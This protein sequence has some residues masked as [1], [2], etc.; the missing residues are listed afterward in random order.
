MKTEQICPSCG[1]PLAAGSPQGLCP[2]CLMKAGFGTGVAPG[3]GEPTSQPPFSPPP[4][5]DMAKLFPQLE[6]VEL[7]G[8]GGMGA[9]YKA[10]QPALDRWVALK[11]LPPQC[12]ARPGFIERFNREARAL[13]RLNHANIVAMHEFG[14][15]GGMPYFVMEY[16]EGVTLRCLVQERRLEPREALKIVPQICEA[17]QFA[18]DEGVVHRDIKPENILLDKKGRVK[19][20]DFGIAKIM[21]ETP[22]AASSPRDGERV[23][24]RPGEDTL[25]QDQVLG[26]PRY[27]AP[28]QVEHPQTVDHRADIYSLG[29]V[30]YEMLT[31]QLPLGK[32]APPSR[33]VQIDVR[34]DGIVLHALEKEPERRY[35]QAS[36]VK[37]D[38]ESIGS[39]AAPIR[40]SPGERGLRIPGTKLA[41]VESRNGQRLVNWKNVS[42]A[43]LLLVLAGPLGLNLIALVVNLM[44]FGFNYNALQK[45]S[46]AMAFVA[47]AFVAAFVM[48]VVV[49]RAWLLRAHESETPSRHTPRP[50]TPERGAKSVAWSDVLGNLWALIAIVLVVGKKV[51]RTQPIM[52]SF[53]G[54]GGWYYP[55][56]YNLLVAVCFGLAGACL[57]IPRLIRPGRAQGML[58]D[59]LVWTD[60]LGTVWG[61]IALV[62]LVGRKVARTE[63]TMY[64]FFDVG[65]WYYP[66]SY[67][68]LVAVCFGFALACLVIPRLTRRGASLGRSS[69]LEA[70]QG[71]PTAMPVRSSAGEPPSV[72]AAASESP[73][74]ERVQNARR[75]VR[76]PA[77]GLMAIGLIIV[78]NYVIILGAS[79]MRQL[80]DYRMAVLAAIVCLIFSLPGLPL[81]VFPIWALMVL[82]RPDVRAAFKDVARKGASAPAA[83]PPTTGSASVP[84]LGVAWKI[85]TGVAAV[86]LLVI[87]VA[88]GSKLL[89]A[90]GHSQARQQEVSAGAVVRVQEKLRNAIQERLAEGGWKVESLNVGVAPDLK[91]AE[92]R[93]G[94]IWKNGLWEVPRPRAA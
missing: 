35:Q 38:L 66:P 3:P 15:V 42:L 47:T 14:Q 13:A 74:L 44:G 55:L 81:A 31:G 48:A 79:R 8:R 22:P 75:L 49:R 62:L 60:V 43:W 67:H 23:A 18:H 11:V 88:V 50:P 30:F 91:R 84:R 83:T 51:A 82:Y 40:S 7:L 59:S 94:A 57:V 45:V 10:R 63:P 80:Q 4:L 78:I 86:A 93:F 52:Y 70:G 76:W 71:S 73:D 16:V 9:V 39:T 89:A 20:A 32:F 24:V 27:M 92:C 46:V 56:S 72:K 37:T 26:T 68:L 64:S 54:V 6:I 25:T 21:V 87:A 53:F 2:E 5:A 77:T 41:L 61:L 28:E 65:G 29:V 58:G 85:V 33:K 34:L 17:L 1:R 36:E 12:T 69:D 90:Y 19:I